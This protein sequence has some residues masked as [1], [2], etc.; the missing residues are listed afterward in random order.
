MKI[1]ITKWAL[2]RGI[3]EAEAAMGNGRSGVI[4]LGNGD[5]FLECEYRTTYE[6]A[7]LEFERQKAARLVV[8]MG[9]VKRLKAK[10]PK[11]ARK[12]CR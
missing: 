5:M 2:S 11:L 7:A 8:L 12:R 9:Q 1:Y 3:V 10:K 4:F 6:A